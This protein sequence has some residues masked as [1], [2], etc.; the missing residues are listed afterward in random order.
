MS[1]CWKGIKAA[2]DGFNYMQTFEY[3]KDRNVYTHKVARRIGSLVSKIYD[4]E[5]LRGTVVVGVFPCFVLVSSRMLLT[6]SL[7]VAVSASRTGCW[8]VR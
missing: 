3:T 4:S 7:L 6:L 8:A 1:V 2:A 5:Q